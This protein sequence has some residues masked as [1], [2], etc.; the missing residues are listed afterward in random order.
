M[1]HH[2]V[3]LLNWQ[4]IYSNTYKSRSYANV[5]SLSIWLCI[6]LVNKNKLNVRQS[7]VRMWQELNKNEVDLFLVARPIGLLNELVL[8]ML[9]TTSDI[10]N[11]YRQYKRKIENSKNIVIGISSPKQDELAVYIADNQNALSHKEIYCLGAALYNEHRMVYDKLR[12]NW[13][14]M[15][16]KDPLRFVRKVR[17]TMVE[18]TSLLNQTKRTNFKNFID[19]FI[20]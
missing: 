14:L 15:F 10:E 12:L 7:G 11:W 3:N 13:L 18:M 1:I 16:F 8:P 2:Y 17:L 4:W 20:N 19:E 9:E 5:D 6:R